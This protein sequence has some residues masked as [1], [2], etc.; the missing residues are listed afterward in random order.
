[1]GVPGIRECTRALKAV[2][3][4]RTPQRFAIKALAF[5]EFVDVVCH[6]VS[7]SSRRVRGAAK[8]EMIALCRPYRA[9]PLFPF[10]YPGFRFAHPGLSYDGP[11]GLAME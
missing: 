2:T 10:C 4:D 5:R 8:G 1:M 3:S 7:C 11:P 9:L 6:Y